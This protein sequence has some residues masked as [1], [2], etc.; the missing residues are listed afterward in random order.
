MT[1]LGTYGHQAF[2]ITRLE[3]EIVCPKNESKFKWNRKRK[4]N[5]WRKRKAVLKAV[6]IK[7]FK[8]SSP[9]E[10]RFRAPLEAK[11]G[12]K[13]ISI[14]KAKADQISKLTF[15]TKNRKCFIKIFNS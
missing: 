1:L 14:L 10:W 13:E 11:T 7:R 3:E 9:V 4:M 12:L 5:L 8:A 15:K 2:S 6:K